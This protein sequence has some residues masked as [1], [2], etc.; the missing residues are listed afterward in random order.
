[1]GG[2]TPDLA[3]TNANATAQLDPQAQAGPDVSG[4]ARLRYLMQQGQPQPIDVARLLQANPADRDAMLQLLQQTYGNGYVQQVMIA[5]QSLPSEPKAIGSSGSSFAPNAFPAPSKNPGDKLP[6]NMTQ[7]DA[8]ANRAQVP[9]PPGSLYPDGQDGLQGQQ[10]PSYIGT[11]VPVQGGPGQVLPTPDS[12]LTKDGTRWTDTSTTTNGRG[13]MQTTVDGTKVV[14]VPGSDLSPEAEQAALV[15]YR[16]AVTAALDDQIKAIDPKHVP[17]GGS[18][19]AWDAKAQQADLAKQKLAVA[20]ASSADLDAIVAKNNLLVARPDDLRASKVTTTTQGTNLGGLADGSA[21]AANNT[22]TTTVNTTPGGPTTTTTS[23]A[24]NEVSTKGANI[25]RS[26]GTM[27]VDPNAGSVDGS[28]SKKSLTGGI[29]DP[30]K[31]QYS[32]TDTHADAASGSSTVTTKTIGAQ[33]GNGFAGLSGSASI[34]KG[35]PAKVDPASDGTSVAPAT[36]TARPSATIAGQAG[37]IQND[38]G[39]GVQAGVSD[40]RVDAGN[41]K[42][43]G[44]AYG[45]VDGSMQ[46][47][48]TPTPDGG[49][50]ITFTATVHAKIGAFLGKRDAAEPTTT[51]SQVSASAGAY[52]V[53][54]RIVTR[55]KKLSKEQAA[56]IIGDLD[57]LASGVDGQGKKTFGTKAAAA[58]YTRVFNSKLEDLALGDPKPGPG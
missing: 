35:D 47:L 15:R 39:T 28:S 38:K 56:E 9:P 12:S 7:A 48:V 17:L 2:T 57:K 46:V 8:D 54:N 23:S 24:V 50:V 26:S 27:T 1:M 44:G 32:T 40:A 4:Q 51:G 11:N 53:H 55:T 49:V 20:T 25:S 5:S 3:S 16:A 30:L 18:D 6:S 13:Q 42:V 31:A 10:T 33:S 36:S 45:A 41:A 34:A 43:A 29:T 52:G 37:V 58:A 22:S 14:A 19:E 21:I